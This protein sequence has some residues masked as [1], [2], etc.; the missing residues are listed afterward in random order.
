MYT[1]TKSQISLNLKRRCQKHGM[2]DAMWIK[3]ATK[4]QEMPKPSPR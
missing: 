1:Y 4:G 3:Q 2:L